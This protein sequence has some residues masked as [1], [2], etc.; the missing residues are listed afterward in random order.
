MNR[1]VEPIMV[2]GFSGTLQPKL[3]PW[4]YRYS[5]KLIAMVKGV[6]DGDYRDWGK[7]RR[8]SRQVSKVV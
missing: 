5:L 4:Y 1:N 8:W 6:E 7:I 3:M 2:A